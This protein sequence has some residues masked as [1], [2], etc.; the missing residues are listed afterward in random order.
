VRSSTLET[1]S[2]YAT[3]HVLGLNRTAL[4]Y[5]GGAHLMLGVWTP[6]LLGAQEPLRV[7][8]PRVCIELRY[9]S[10]GYKDFHAPLPKA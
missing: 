9:Q 7:S 8:C 2:P 3:G 5:T 10:S 4:R 1:V 6:R